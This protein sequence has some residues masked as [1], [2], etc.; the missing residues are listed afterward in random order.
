MILVS[1]H[2]M[3]TA[4]PFSQGRVLKGRVLSGFQIFSAKLANGGFLLRP[5][6]GEAAADGGIAPGPTIPLDCDRDE[7][8]TGSDAIA[9][10]SERQQSRRF[11]SQRPSGKRPSQ[12]V[13]HL[14]L[15]RPLVW[16]AATHTVAPKTSRPEN[17]IARGMSLHCHIQIFVLLRV[18][19]I[20]QT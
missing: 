9:R 18:C 13:R 17:W 14:A 20:N 3:R 2:A 4:V 10:A 7:C 12:A 8:T 11:P 16:K 1:G 6:F 15:E 19:A 5:P